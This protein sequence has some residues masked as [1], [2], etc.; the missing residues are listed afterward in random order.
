MQL[1]GARCDRLVWLVLGEDDKYPGKL[2]DG[3]RRQLRSDLCL[4]SLFGPAQSRQSVINGWKGFT[5]KIGC[6]GS[7]F[8]FLSSP[9]FP[10]S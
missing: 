9:V 7:K 1:K 5:N 10:L 2:T 6:D 3:C 8:S 4:E